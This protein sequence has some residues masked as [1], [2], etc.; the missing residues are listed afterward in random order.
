M[1]ELQVRKKDGRTEPFL[2]TKIYDGVVKSGGTPDQA[3]KIT[4]DIEAWAPSAAVDGA[5]NTSDIRVKV[6]EAL[7]VENPA[8]AE[9]FETYKK[10]QPAMETPVEPVAAPVSEEVVAETPVEEPVAETPVESA[11]EMPAEETPAPVEPPAVE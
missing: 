8:A 1:P 6:L 11:P 10:E 9:Q 4:A 2:R 5:V 7:K 3:E